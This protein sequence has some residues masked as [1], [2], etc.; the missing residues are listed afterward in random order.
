VTLTEEKLIELGTALARSIGH[1][2]TCPKV[3]MSIPCVCGCA[4]LQAKAL[5]DWQ[6]LMAEIKEQ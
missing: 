2:T 1:K 4:K 6:H 3:T 5:D